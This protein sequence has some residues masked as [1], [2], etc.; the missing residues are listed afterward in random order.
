MEQPHPVERDYYAQGN[1]KGAPLPKWTRPRNEYTTQT[2]APFQCS[3]VNTSK[4][5][6]V[7][8]N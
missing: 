7:E 8:K 4:D 5:S 1:M 3:V 2:M 6:H